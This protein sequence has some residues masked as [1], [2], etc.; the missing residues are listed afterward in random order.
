VLFEQA[1]CAKRGVERSHLA[2]YAIVCAR[3]R[4]VEADRHTPRVERRDLRR[5]AVHQGAVCHHPEQEPSF[6]GGKGNLVKVRPDEDLAAGQQQK[7]GSGL[8]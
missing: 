8:Q 7:W 3:V 1:R 5:L 6:P 2:G 4:T